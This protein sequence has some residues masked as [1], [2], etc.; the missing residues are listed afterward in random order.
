[1]LGRVD[2]LVQNLAG[3][4]HDNTDTFSHNPAGQI[5]SRTRTNTGYSYAAHVN[6]DILFGHNGLNP[7][8]SKTGGPA[9]TYDGRGNM[10]SGGATTFGF[11]P[12]NRAVPGRPPS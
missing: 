12:Y 9:P 1:M 5:T 7:I 3:A 6:V 4:A 11:D 2:E 8:T 10:T